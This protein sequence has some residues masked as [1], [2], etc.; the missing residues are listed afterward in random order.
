MTMLKFICLIIKHYGGILQRI[1]LD[2]SGV[3]ISISSEWNEILDV[4]RKD[5]WGFC[6]VNVSEKLKIDIEIKIIKSTEKP[7]FPVKPTSMQTQNALTYDLGKVRY[8]DYYGKAFTVIDFEKEDARIYGEDFDKIHEIAYLMILSRAGKILDLKGLHKL[9]AFAVS[10][11]GIAFVCMMPS[12][13]GKSTLLSE[14]LKDSRIKMLSDDIPMVDSLGRV[15][16]F[17]LKLGFNEIP[18]HLKVTNPS[19]NIYTMNRE[20]HGLKKLICIKGIEDRVELNSTYSKIVLAEGFR[21]HSDKSEII[22]TSWLSNFK[23]LFRHGVIGVG[24]PIVIEYFWEPGIRDF[25]KKT[26]IFFKRLLAF[27]S[28]SLRAKKI[29]IHIG[30]QPGIAAQSIVNYLEK[31]SNYN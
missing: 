22:N 5:F 29:K 28:L 2:I 26:L 20:L 16:S 7:E 14:L 23:G 30:N 1:L 25:I 27:T 6:N 12:K 8:C 9:H 10:F 24:S 17:P 18:E 21:I 13:G 15:S 3:N 11:N 19:E 4:L 31:I